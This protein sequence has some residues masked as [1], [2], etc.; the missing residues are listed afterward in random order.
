M[1]KK[2]KPIKENSVTI[3]DTT[4]PILEYKDQRVITLAMMDKLHHAPEGT[5]GRNFMDNKHNFEEGKHY[6]C[7]S[8]RDIKTFDEFHRTSLSSNPQ[9]VI[10]ITERGYSMLVKSFTDDF[11][12][13]VQDQLVDSYFD[14]KK[15][16]STAEFLV[17]QANLILEHD[18]KLKRLEQ[19]QSASEIHLAETRQEL[20]ITSDK[21]EKAF[22]A[23]SAA[24]RYKYGDSDSYTIVGFCN[25]KQIKIKTSESSVRGAQA[26]SLSRQ[27]GKNII[28]IPDERYGEVNSYHVSIL[29]EVFKD[30]LSEKILTSN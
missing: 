1:E 30:K 18:V 21:A 22:E 15:P 10:V 17:Q 9:G 28:K 2:I 20:R 12:W 29:E 11:A 24:L 8:N 5:A 23:A 3:I 13:E 14:N 25:K 16:M 19:R 4:I 7:L 26:S 6:F 27:R